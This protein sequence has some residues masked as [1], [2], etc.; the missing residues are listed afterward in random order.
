MQADTDAWPHTGRLLPWM[1]AGFMAMVWLV[2][3]DAVS[4]PIPLPLDGKLDRLALGA[5]LLM[6]V[7]TLFVVRGAARP[8][9]WFTWIHVAAAA[10]ILIVIAGAV[11][12]AHDLVNL[13]EF[14]LV[15]KKLALLL[16]GVLF[17]VIVA[18]VVRVSEVPS[19]ITLM[20]GLSCVAALGILIEYRLHY[21][22]F[23]QLTAKALPGHV[24]MPSDLNARDST[25]RVQV[26]GP[27]GHPLETAALMGL[28]LPFALGR[29]LD[30]PD[31]RQKLINGAI[32]AILVAGAFATLRKTSVIA[33]AAGVLVLLAYRPRAM[34]RAF[35]PFALGMFV[36]VHVVAPG[37]LGSLTTQ[38]TPNRLVGVLSTQDRASDFDGT[39]PDYANHVLLG[40]GYQS[41]DPH[42]YR[43]LDNQYLG[44]ILGVGLLGLAAYLAVLVATG[45]MAHA[46]VR[47]GDPIRGPVALG[48][49]AATAVMI[50]ST[51]L[52]DLLSYP[53]VPYLFFFIGGL[54][55]ACT[56]PARRP[57]PAPILTRL[58]QGAVVQ[59]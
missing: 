43:T 34:F 9:L 33:P 50:V 55:V 56:R 4:L 27:G 52:F 51:G 7:T 10:L 53:H 24:V 17:F 49:A 46:G 41:Y 1:L 14:T 5:L 32:S 40:R 44:L 20:L 35:L 12:N 6:W 26:Y 48:A 47:S 42:K 37:A 3:F 25:G 2:P 15:L 11:L 57:A 18:S 23:Y 19:F 8:R 13:G 28:A 30:A 59:C 38:L 21:N 54:V 45:L 31:R 22:P 58:E 36:M 16:S 29:M 39:K